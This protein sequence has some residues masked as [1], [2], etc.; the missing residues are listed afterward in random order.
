MKRKGRAR[1]PSR[2]G[3]PIGAIEPPWFE[4]L[5][6][7]WVVL[8]EVLERYYVDRLSVG[9]TAAACGLNSTTV[10]AIIQGTKWTTARAEAIKELRARG[11]DTSP[12]KRD[13]GTI[14]TDEQAEDIEYVLRRKHVDGASQAEITRE[15]RFEG[16]QSFVVSV[17]GGTRWQPAIA[18]VLDALRAEG[19]LIATPLA[20]HRYLARRRR[21]G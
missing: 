8:R 13:G 14:P 18:H 7:D 17:C 2:D 1:R 12:R 9:D 10:S 20:L 3:V 19:Y 5:P 4:M 15:P 6:G 11:V 16:R 21:A